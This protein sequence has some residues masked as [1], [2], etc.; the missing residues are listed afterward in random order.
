MHSYDVQLKFLIYLFG[1]V[2]EKTGS[3]SK[4]NHSGSPTL[5]CT[6]PVH[7]QLHK[8][9]GNTVCCSVIEFTL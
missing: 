7:C 9:S 6:V 8:Q 4:I 2:L 5:Q 1:L 3:G